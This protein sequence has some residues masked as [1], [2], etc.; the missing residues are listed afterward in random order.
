MSETA[1]VGI[2]IDDDYCGRCSICSSICPYEAI[3]VV[4]ETGEV[5]LDVEKCQLC[6]LCYSA[7]PVAAI[8]MVYYDS[9]YF[10]KRIEDAA[11]EEAKT[12][13]VMMCRGNSPPNC[14][15]G[16][17]LE[18]GNSDSFLSLRVPCVGRVPL[19]FILKTLTLG[20]KQIVTVR[21]EEDFCRFKEGSRLSDQKLGLTGQVLKELGYGEDVL[22]SVTF[23]RKAVYITDDCVG[24]D[25]CVFICPYEAIGMEHFA[26]PMVDPEKCVGCG[27]CA[28]VCPHEAIQIE[29]F[30]QKSVSRNIKQLGA[31]A[32]KLKSSGVSPLVLAFCCQ[33]SEFSALDTPDTWLCDGR[34]VTME[35]PC[36]KGLDPFHVVE[37]LHLGFDGVLAYVCSSSDCKLEIG[38]G[39]GARN[40]EVLQRVLKRWNLQDRFQIHTGSP[41]DVGDFDGHL[42]KFIKKVGSLP[43]L[44]LENLPVE[45][46]G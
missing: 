26:T 33:W 19:E 18:D 13:L 21:C 3:S 5:R 39:I 43:P 45:S 9:E 41:R 6:G 27:A 28:L 29:G 1:I 36:F 11:R 17:V 40:T 38:Y 15:L 14:K 30:E 42:K 37:A 8:E 2:R 4:A 23:A 34:V 35:V 25:K 10:L 44:A 16:K 20:I 46:A 32:K 7:C 22:K 12:K 31:A 24:C